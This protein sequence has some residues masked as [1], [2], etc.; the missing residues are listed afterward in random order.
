MPAAY[1]RALDVGLAEIGVA[2]PGDQREAIDGH[3]RLLLAW[4]RVINLTAIRDPADVAIGH[5]VD[6]LAALPVLRE[7]G[8]DRSVDLGS[9]GGFPGLPLAIALPAARTLLADSVGKKVRFLDAVIEATA[10]QG[11]VETYAGRV[12]TLARDP[13]HRERWPAATVRAV[14]SL[15]E[16]AELAF[17]LLEPGGILIAWKRGDIDEELAAAERAAAALGGGGLDALTVP[18]PSLPRHCLVVMSKAGRTPNRYPRD[19][20]QRRRAPW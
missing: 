10:L 14:A 2:L 18:A 6:S 11:R 17:P 15:P 3:V 5:V 9:G 7:R 4:N 20:A 12:E 19:T 8:V 13:L 16:L 1:G